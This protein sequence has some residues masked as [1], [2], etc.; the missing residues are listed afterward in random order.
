MPRVLIDGSGE[1]L[2]F[3]RFKENQVFSIVTD[4]ELKNEQ[5]R[6]DGLNSVRNGVFAVPH[7][8]CTDYYTD[9]YRDLQGCFVSEDGKE[10]F[11]DLE[12][13]WNTPDEWWRDAV[14]TAEPRTR[15]IRL[16]VENTERLRVILS[17][18]RACFPTRAMLW[19]V[20]PDNDNMV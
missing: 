19:G 17:L 10:I 7:R 5:F 15:A 16:H 4:D 18:Y 1:A 14:Q 3:A 9:L 12:P 6:L 20:R 8:V 13:F 11:L 2:F